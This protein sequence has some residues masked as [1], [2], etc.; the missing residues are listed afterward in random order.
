MLAKITVAFLELC[1]IWMVMLYHVVVTALFLVSIP[2]FI[3]IGVCWCML[4]CG[5][6]VDRGPCEYLR[7]NF[8]VED[9][10]F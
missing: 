4:W 1:T 7:E 3:V 6:C 9:F 10:K 5:K 2:I 8:N